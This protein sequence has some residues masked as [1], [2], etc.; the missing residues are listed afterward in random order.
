MCFS[1]TRDKDKVEVVK[2]VKKK[3]R[4]E[5]SLDHIGWK[6]LVS[7][8]DSEGFVIGLTKLFSCTNH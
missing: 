1:F 7:K 4:K 6:G 5:A 2:N 8:S 3:K